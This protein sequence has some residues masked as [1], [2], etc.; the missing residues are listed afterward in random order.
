MR[1]RLGGSKGVLKA[2]HFT[3]VHLGP[4]F[5]LLRLQKLVKEIM[6]QKPDVIFFT[7]D[8]IDRPLHYNSEK[9]AGR[10]LSCLKAPYGKYAVLGNHDYRGDDGRLGKS[11]LKTAGFTFL[12]NQAT[13]FITKAGL[14]VN[15]VGLAD[16]IYQKPNYTI[17]KPPKGE[18][19]TIVLTHE[20]DFANKIAARRPDIILA[21]H[22]HGGQ[23]RLP[24]MGP[25]ITTKHA[26]K[27]VQGLYKV[28][29][30][31]L[32]V[33]SGIGTSSLPGRFLAP[34]GFSVLQIV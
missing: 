22:S 16:T 29:Q 26:H 10:I 19:L 14:W 8:L 5:S 25:V 23:F 34:P 6:L 27:Y 2:A 31:L 33:D 24:V 7:G 1:T 20:G 13:G 11:V 15:V 9:E 21:G 4:H 30:S 18:Q 3:D 17:I 28:R 12:N 32:Y